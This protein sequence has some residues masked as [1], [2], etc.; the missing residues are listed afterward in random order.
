[1]SEDVTPTGQRPDGTKAQ[2]GLQNQ[3][4]MW[5]TQNA[6]DGDKSSLR[7]EASVRWSTPT[8]VHSKS[9]KAMRSSAEGGQS[10][11]PGIGQQ[12]SNLAS[13][14]PDLPIS[15]DGDGSSHIRRT[16]NPLFVEWLM[17]WPRGWTLVGLMLPAS[18]DCAC[19]AM[20]LSAWKQRMRSALSSLAS[21]PPAMPAQLSLLG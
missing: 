1:M 14:L 9:A 19:S 4:R 15:T 20:A 10:S 17:G 16:L 7:N 21:P 18:I 3:V 6:T 2:V 8:M 5:P 12:A 13:I 11:P